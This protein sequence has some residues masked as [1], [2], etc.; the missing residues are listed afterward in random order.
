MPD[1]AQSIAERRIVFD[2]HEERYADGNPICW[3]KNSQG[4]VF[5]LTKVQS[6][7]GAR[8]VV[9]PLLYSR[10]KALAVFAKGSGN[11]IVITEKIDSRRRGIGH[12]EPRDRLSFHGASIAFE[13]YFY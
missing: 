7:R 5:A 13:R 12:N 6:A 3:E 11:G 9:S 10:R 4:C 8:R 2:V 1:G